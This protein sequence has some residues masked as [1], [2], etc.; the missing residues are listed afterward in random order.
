[1]LLHYL[2][3]RNELDELLRMKIK[4]LGAL[5]IR[6]GYR[7][8]V[9]FLRCEGCCVSDKQVHCIASVDSR[10]Q[11]TEVVCP[12]PTELT[13]LKEF[14]APQR[15]FATTKVERNRPDVHDL[16][17]AELRRYGVQVDKLRVI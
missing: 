17:I 4:E 5:R 16:G 12:R 6:H 13:W 3:K 1:M 10:L 8:L 7:R 9:V 2:A 14:P 15:R 11:R